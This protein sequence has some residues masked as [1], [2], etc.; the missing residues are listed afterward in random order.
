[1]TWTIAIATVG[2]ILASAFFVAVEFSLIAARRHRL[3]EQAQTSGSARA[4]LRSSTEL[5]LLLA[6]SQL[7]ITMCTLAL[8]AVTKPAVHHLLTPLMEDLGLPDRTADAVAFVLALIVV[9]FLHLVIG[10]MMPKSWAIAHPERAATLLAIPMRAFMAVFRP[11]LRMLNGA[12]NRLVRM[13]GVEPVDELAGGQDP[14]ALRRLVEHSASVGVLDARFGTPISMAL[15]LS[16]I[17]IGEVVTTG[18]PIASVPSDATV[19]DVQTAARDSGHARILVRDGD[20][21]RSI[22][23]IR[24]TLAGVEDDAPVRTVARPLL[25]LRGSTPLFEALTAMRNT[26]NQLAMVIHDGREVGVL[27]MDDILPRLLPR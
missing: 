24:D 25:R 4:A 9:T 27:T 7:G 5:T 19:L 10:E 15:D 8:G 2:L 26:R 3:E 22:V 6:G 1:M 14:Q 17:T 20:R 13:L 16:E 18:R 21:H 23:H 12:A 11:L